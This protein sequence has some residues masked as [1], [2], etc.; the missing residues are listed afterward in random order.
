M[1]MLFLRLPKT[2]VLSAQVRRDSDTQDRASTVSSLISCARLGILHRAMELVESQSLIRVQHSMMRILPSS[3]PA[4]V[5]IIML[6]LTSA[7]V[8]VVSYFVSYARFAFPFT[9]LPRLRM[10]INGECRAKYKSLSILS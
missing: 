4:Q 1:P 7:E 8:N 5:N 2:S 3:T 6:L 9:L 10:F